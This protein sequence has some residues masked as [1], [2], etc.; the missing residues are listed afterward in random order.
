MRGF[1][2]G[3]HSKDEKHAKRLRSSLTRFLCSVKKKAHKRET[4]FLRTKLN[5]DPFGLKLRDRFID[6]LFAYHN[7]SARLIAPCTDC[8]QAP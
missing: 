7:H 6:A 2:L 8:V 4:E 3:F 1:S 5:F